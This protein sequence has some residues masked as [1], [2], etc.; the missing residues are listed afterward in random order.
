MA[1]NGSISVPSEIDVYRVHLVPNVDYYAVAAGGSGQRGAAAGLTLPDPFVGVLDAETQSIVASDDN[2][3]GRDAITPFTVPAEK[4]YYLAVGDITGGTGSY[5]TGIIERVSGSH[6]TGV[7]FAE[8]V[9]DPMT[10][11]VVPAGSP[12]P[13]GQP[14]QSTQQGDGGP[15]GLLFAQPGTDPSQFEVPGLFSSG[16]MGVQGS[17]FTPDSILG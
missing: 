16:T 3:Q 9:V 6:V 8:F 10:G 5:E 2:S 11:Q 14:G 4:D 1:F 12:G 7:M 17:G 15:T 13:M